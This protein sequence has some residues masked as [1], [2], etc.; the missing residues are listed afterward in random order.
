MYRP[1]T[2]WRRDRARCSSMWRKLRPG[3]GYLAALV[4]D[5]HFAAILWETNADVWLHARFRVAVTHL[6]YL[7]GW[8]HVDALDVRKLGR[9]LT[10]SS[11]GTRFKS[12]FGCCGRTRRSPSLI[13]SFVRGRHGNRRGSHSKFD[14]DR[15]CS[16]AAFVI[17]HKSV[18]RDQESFLSLLTR[19]PWKHSSHAD[20]LAIGAFQ[21]ET[22]LIFVFF[23]VDVDK[24]CG[25]MVKF[26]CSR[27]FIC[28]NMSCTYVY[29]CLYIYIYTCTYIHI[30]YIGVARQTV[31]L[32][33]Q[34]AKYVRH[35]VTF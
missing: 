22:W 4:V 15:R 26:R 18:A 21:R 17:A 24:D 10:R 1:S 8:V 7:V 9:Y 2:F 14:G 23:S 34:F 30:Y 29:F 31:L 13:A 19:G 5:F 16:I 33:L 12:N 11:R 3:Y 6:L 25:H 32:L 20:V 27:A 35:G 28:D